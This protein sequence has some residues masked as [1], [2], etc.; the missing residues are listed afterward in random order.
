M[1]CIFCDIFGGLMRGRIVNCVWL[2]I[3]VCW[4]IYVFLILGL[5]CSKKIWF[6]L[7]FLIKLVCYDV[8]KFGVGFMLLYFWINVLIIFLCGVGMINMLIV[9]G[10]SLGFK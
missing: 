5:L 8:D 3:N 7:L 1:V 2:R 9:F 4:F 6:F 10:L